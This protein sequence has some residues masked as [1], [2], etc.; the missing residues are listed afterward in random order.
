MRISKSDKKFHGIKAARRILIAM[1]AVSALATALVGYTSFRLSGIVDPAVQAQQDLARSVYRRTHAPDLHPFDGAPELT[2]WAWSGSAAMPEPDLVRAKSVLLACADSGEVLFEKNADE[3]IPPASMTKLVAMYTALRAVANGEVSLDD[4]VA[5][6]EE[7]WARNIPPGSS[8]MFLGPGQ[9]VTMDEIL[10]GMAVVSGNDAAIALACH[11]SGSVPAFVARMNDE[12]RRLGLRKTV[13]VEPSGLSENNRTTAREF[14]S[15]ALSYIREFPET[16]ERY[17]SKRDLSYPL[18]G[19]RAKGNNEPAVYQRATNTLL[20]TLEGCDGLKTGF[21]YESGFNICLTAERN[22]TRFLALI[23]GGP[24]RTIR[25]GVRIRDRDGNSIMEW[26]FANRRVVPTRD[27]VPV[28]LTVWGGRETSLWAIPAGTGFM[29]HPA[30][31]LLSVQTVLPRS[32]NAPIA[33]GTR[34]GSVDYLAD[35]KVVHSVPLVADR[36]IE[37]AP[38]PLVLLDYLASRCAELLLS[39]GRRSE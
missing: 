25:E 20:A 32:I 26:V 7:S 13:F 10:T 24:G 21:I 5:L 18:P 23:M 1:L 28:P 30:G 4:S 19:N 35:G 17:H 33:A 27:A 31:A 14:A 8:L 22:G 36:N 2:T 37:R 6:P 29:V 34:I 11:V 9:N 39:N 15:F 16:L 3:L 38:G 12:I